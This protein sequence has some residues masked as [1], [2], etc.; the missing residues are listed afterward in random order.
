MYIVFLQET[1][2]SFQ[3]KDPELHFLLWLAL[4]CV[5]DFGFVQLFK[6]SQRRS[7][8]APTVVSINYLTMAGLLGAYFFF[9]TTPSFTVKTVQIGII[10]GVTCIVGMLIT[11]KALQML[12]VSLVLTSYR[13]SLVVPV[14]A[15]VQ[16]WGETLN[17][18]QTFGIMAALLGLVFITCGVQPTDRQP[19]A[20]F[21]L[22]IVPLIFCAQ[23]ICHCCVR[24]VH[25]A[26]LDDRFLHVLFMIGLTAGS[27]GTLVVVLA[28]HR[29]ARSEIFTGVGIGLYNLVAFSIILS[30]LAH[31]PGTIFFPTLGCTVV[32]LD[33][34]LAYL[35]W[36][37]PPNRSV[38]WGI[39]LAILALFF[40]LQP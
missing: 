6:Y 23:G 26:G 11:T 10:T 28:R 19:T 25:Y 18:V 38:R 30:A 27:L 16:I 37:E 15:S 12:N 31:V 13:M 36:K 17:G 1:P 20:R 33:Q 39:V 5:A 14:V 34:F 40:V 2:P 29:P 9:Q 3:R 32:I 21:A 35:V 7:H 22:C 24:W 4:A 8:H